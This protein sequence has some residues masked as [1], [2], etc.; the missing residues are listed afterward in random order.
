MTSPIAYSATTDR[1]LH[2]DADIERRVGRLLGTAITRQLWLMF[3]DRNNRQLS[4]LVPIDNAPVRPGP[5]DSDP[6]VPLLESLAEDQQVV[7]VILV[8]ERY[9]SKEIQNSDIE[10]A[11]TVQAACERAR[12][13]L[14]AVLVS[15][16]G[17]IRW[18]RPSEFATRD[19]SSAE[20]QPS[21]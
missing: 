8:L 13:T 10:W 20:G 7:G 2:T 9:A 4:L 19:G 11:R 15:H 21:S 14:R 5:N 17:G 18:L 1:P 6:F 16:S 12:V 3:T